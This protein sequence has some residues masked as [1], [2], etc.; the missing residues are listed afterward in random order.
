M[1]KKMV[2]NLEKSFYRG[3]AGFL[4]EGRYQGKIVDLEEDNKRL[5]VENY[6]LKQEVEESRKK[7]QAAE[8][9]IKYMKL[10][11]E[12]AVRKVREELKNEFDFLPEDAFQALV[13]AEYQFRNERE[14]IDYT[15]IYVEYIKAIE[16]F[17]GEYFK[18]ENLT[19]GK[20]V[21]RL[22]KKEGCETLARRM[23]E[24][25]ITGKRNRGVHKARMYK[26][27][28]GKLRQLIFQERW[29][30]RIAMAFGTAKSNDY[31]EKMVTVNSFIIKTDGYEQYGDKLYRCYSTGNSWILSDKNIELG[32]INT[33]GKKVLLDGVEYIII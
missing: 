26:N 24:E 20:M 25:G 11:K 10:E 15:G 13:T 16:L 30:E 4:S 19:F 32:R 21:V 14:D 22:A 3:L 23:Q 1:R 29:L 17:L 33:L 6:N 7:L 18:E 2:F 9:L 12:E 31:Q 5:E 8:S 27:E 28:C